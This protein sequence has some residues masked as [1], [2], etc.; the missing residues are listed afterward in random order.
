M[1]SHANYRRLESIG[2]TLAHSHPAFF[3]IS[4]ILPFN[5][6]S[7]DIL[8]RHGPTGRPSFRLPP[9]KKQLK[10]RPF[11]HAHCFVP[12]PVCLHFSR[13]ALPVESRPFHGLSNAAWLE[14]IY[15]FHTIL[16]L[17][18]HSIL[19]PLCPFSNVYEYELTSD[20][21]TQWQ[22]FSEIFPGCQRI[23]NRRWPIITP[24]HLIYQS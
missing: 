23:N 13:S 6:A 20:R 3:S 4:R 12:A 1:T 5:S 7:F 19:C 10:R 21:I 22:K 8:S 17:G 18:P 24:D 9:I 11:E 2:S 15:I 16:S 14:M